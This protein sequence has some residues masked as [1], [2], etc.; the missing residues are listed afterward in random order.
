[1]NFL[2]PG[3]T[4][5]S[6]SYLWVIVL[7]FFIS[8]PPIFSK[9]NSIYLEAN[10]IH[11]SCFVSPSL[12]SSLVNYYYPQ[13]FNFP[14]KGYAIGLKFG[15]KLSESFGIN[16]EPTFYHF[17]NK[18]VVYSK[19]D[20]FINPLFVDSLG[21]KNEAVVNLTALPIFFSYRFHQFDF[22]LGCWL[23]VYGT[24]SEKVY[25]SHGRI[26]PFSGNCS[27]N[28]VLSFMATADWRFSKKLELSLGY[29][30]N[31]HQFFDNDIFTLGLAYK[32]QEN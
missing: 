19:P 32:L 30:R 11:N 20:L 27:T 18:V 26:L 4:Q 7:S 24:F 29:I 9:S 6:Q 2:S 1:M 13:T 23:F 17:N 10:V 3:K 15:H 14:S 12:P 25:F 22:N 16:I 5:K 21:S 31:V 28:K 8:H